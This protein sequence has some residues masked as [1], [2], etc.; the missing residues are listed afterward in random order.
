MGVPQLRL[1]GDWEKAHVLARKYRSGLLM[2]R[3]F[4]R[5]VAQEAQAFRREVVQGIRKQAPGGQAFTPLHPLTIL[6]KKSSKALIDT[7]SMFQSIAV[8]RLD[9]MTFF[10][11]VH[12]TARSKGGKPLANIA[13]LHE[14]GGRITMRITQAMFHWFRTFLRAVRVAGPP[15]DAKGRFS[16]TTARRSGGGGAQP[17][18]R[19]G[20]ILVIVIPARPFMQPTF[21]ALYGPGGEKAGAAIMQRVAVML[22]RDFGMPTFARIT[23]SGGGGPLGSL[24]G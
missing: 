12:R 24:G 20:A 14:K 11:G 23:S 7:G 1:V 17:A 9:D 19:I 13:E 8:H 6:K 22:G 3:A 5:A 2:H 15:R 4:Q 18:F 10:V 16:G 21:D